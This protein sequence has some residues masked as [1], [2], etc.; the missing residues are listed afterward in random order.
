VRRSSDNAEADIGF[1]AN[2]DLDTTALL[3]HVGSQNLLLRSQEFENAAWEGLAGSAETIAANSE[4]APDGTLTA[5]R[6]TVLSSTSGRYQTITLA[7]AGQIT[8]SLFIKAGSTG[9]WARI[10]FFDTAVVTNQARCW[11][12]M[13]TGAIG[14]VSTVGSGWSNATASSTPV[15]NGWY[16]ISLTATST[17]TAISVINTAADADNS[18]SRTIGQNRIIWGAQLNT[19]AT[20]QPYYATTNV[21]RTTGDGFVTT[22]YDQSG[23]GRNATQ[24]TAGQQPRIV[25]AGVVIE[26]LNG[27]PEIRFDGVDDYLAAAS[28]LIGTTHSLFVLFTPTIE[29]QT[30]SLFGQWFSNATGRFTILVNQISSGVASA[31]F[32]NVFNSSATQGGG[33]GGLATEVA[34]SNA[35]TL[36]TSISTTGSEQ[37]KLFKNGAEW[38]S[39]TI[40]SVLTGVNSAI[41]SLNGAG[42]SLPFDGTVSELISFPSVLSTTDRQTLERNQGAYYGIPSLALDQ[43]GVASA[44]AY[45]L[46]KLR[47]AYDGSAVRVRRSSDNTETD[48]GFTASGD[49]NT[50][51]LLAHVGSGSGFVTTWYDQSGNARNATQTTAGIQPRIVNAGVIDIA[52]GKPA[53]RFNGANTFF[54]GVSLPLSQITLSS[55]LNDVT[56]LPNIRYSIGTGSASP[57]RGI[58]SSFTG[59]APPTPNAS[60]GYAPDT[61]SVVQTGFLPTIGQS[62]VVSLTTTATASSIW[63][64]GGNNGTGGRIT[65]N[66]L[67]IGQR[68]DSQWYYDGY[69]SETIV[70]P[71]VL[72]TTD[73]QTLERN[74]GGYYTITVS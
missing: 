49:L 44:A 35:P 56:Q 57:G 52:N 60:L 11:V 30:G 33:S 29:N 65:L 19:G 23:N 17:A 59:F 4:I 28:P 10:G 40:T 66:Q 68:G 73:R 15:G 1:T 46:R 7:A 67:F 72:S 70:F 45:S 12:N 61:G 54:S 34:I 3:A 41:G 5:D 14:T 50:A 51:A 31:G 55:V 38:D 13:L 42:S 62:Y 36:I 63:A 71:S 2:G 37:W 26:A 8:C 64:N 25:N 53:V 6:C 32:L 48:I 21:V 58:F 24:T 47:A 43:I 18:T 39:A 22:W 20:A 27:K 9:T 74:Q 16:R 69:N